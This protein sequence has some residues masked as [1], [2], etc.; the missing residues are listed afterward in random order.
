[1]SSDLGRFDIRSFA[2]SDVIL[3]DV[4]DSDVSDSDEEMFRVFA[5]ALRRD[6]NFV[7][8]EFRTLAKKSL[9]ASSMV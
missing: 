2:L 7:S 8:A 5:A 9:R 6:W 4:S 3:S 1:M